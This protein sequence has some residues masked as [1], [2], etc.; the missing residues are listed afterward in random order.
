MIT[1]AQTDKTTFSRLGHLAPGFKCSTVT[2]EDIDIR[3]LHGKVVLIN[4][5]ATWCPPC[6]LELPALQDRIWKKYKHTDDFVLIVVGRDHNE[7]AIIDFSAEKGFDMPFI[8]DPNRVIYNL[9]ASQYIPRNIIIDRDGKV[10]F[11][12]RGYTEKEFMMIEKILSEKLEQ[13]KTESK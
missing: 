12:N 8:A 10:I 1:D 4:F 11:Q 6:N 7:N 13:D 5:F 9:F 2:G 3:N